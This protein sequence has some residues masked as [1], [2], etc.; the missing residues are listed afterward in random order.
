MTPEGLLDSRILLHK[1][2]DTLDT[3]ETSAEGQSR[4]TLD[5]EKGRQKLELVINGVDGIRKLLAVVERLQQGLEAVIRQRHDAGHR[6]GGIYE[7]GGSSL[8]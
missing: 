7:L 1:T 8:S 6:R 3:S 5:L 2:C 4:L